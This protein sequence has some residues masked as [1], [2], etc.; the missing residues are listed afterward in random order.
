MSL[1]GLNWT[2]P[3]HQL[4][5]V[6]HS[7]YS[8]S[9]IQHIYMHLYIYSKSTWRSDMLPSEHIIGNCCSACKSSIY[10]KCTR[11]ATARTQNVMFKHQVHIYSAATARGHG[12]T[13]NSF[14][15]RF[16]DEHN[17]AII[18]GAL[19]GNAP[20]YTSQ[21]YTQ[22]AR[23]G[24]CISTGGKLSDIRGG[25]DPG[26]PTTPAVYLHLSLLYSAAIISAG[27]PS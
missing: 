8:F 15:G 27:R 4:A 9:L 3:G 17:C 19:R 20:K 26:W 5:C 2:H 13:K 6:S 14:Y 11:N 12:G 25:R 16:V 10:L 18:V 22:S 24:E 21:S 23:G 1:S 7:H